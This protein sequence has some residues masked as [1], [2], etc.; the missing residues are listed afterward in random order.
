MGKV[1]YNTKHV[2]RSMYTGVLATP[3]ARE[4]PP[5]L[6]LLLYDVLA[7]W[8]LVGQCPPPCDKVTHLKRARGDD[9]YARRS[10]E[11]HGTFAPFQLPLRARPEGVR[12]RQ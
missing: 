11:N 1:R 12:L 9:P 10:H 8:Y 6:H 2:L 5:R 4:N 3:F 7:G